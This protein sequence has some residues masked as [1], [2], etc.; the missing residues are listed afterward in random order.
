[1]SS[2][3]ASILGILR[4]LL[5]SV[6]PVRGK[7]FREVPSLV[8]TEVVARNSPE[9]PQDVLLDIFALLEIPDLTRAVRALSAP[10]GAMRIP[11]YAA[12]LNCTKGLRPLASSTPLNLLVR[13]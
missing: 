8:E 13:T 5:V 1:M 12:S 3:H 4:K 2:I 10:P 9:I 7:K 6:I 11:P